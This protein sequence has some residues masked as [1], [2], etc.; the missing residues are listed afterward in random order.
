M[1]IHKHKSMYIKYFVAIFCIA[2]IQTITFAQNSTKSSFRDNYYTAEALLDLG[3]YQEA[4][5]IYLEMSKDAPD[6]DNINFK[7]GFCYVNI[8]LDKHK[9]IPYLEKA[10]QNTSLTYDSNS[11]KETKAPV[12][13]LYWLGKAYHVNYKFEEAINTLNQFRPMIEADNIDLLKSVDITLLNCKNG[14]ELIEKPVKFNIINLGN[15]INTSYSEHSPVF[16]ADESVLIFTS[17]RSGSVGGKK[18]EDGQFYEDIY[19]SLKTDKGWSVPSAISTINS[20][21]NEA[22]IGLSVDGQQLFIY[23]DENGDGNIYFSELNGDTWSVPVKLPEPINTKSRETHASL[24][25]DGRFLYFT[26]DRKGGYGGLD[27]YVS[28]RLPN[29]KWGDVQNLGP[30]INT[31]L[32]EEGPFIHPD[33]VTLFFS[34]EGHQSMGGYDIFYTVIDNETRTCEEPA[35]IGYPINTTEHDVFY[36]PTPDGKRAYYASYQAGGIGNSDIYLITFQDSKEKPL[37]VMSGSISQTTGKV[38]KNVTIT[39]TDLNTKEIVGLYTP[40]S[41][42]GKFLFILTPGNYNILYESDENL[43]FSEN[44]TVDENSSYNQINKA[45]NLAPLVIG[46]T[47]EKYFAEFAPGT[48]EIDDLIAKELDRLTVVLMANKYLIVELISQKNQSKTKLNSDR[49]KSA[50]DY[51]VSKGVD[52]YRIM[53]DLA[54]TPEQDNILQLHITERQDVV[55]Q[56]QNKDVSTNNKTETTGQKNTTEI[57]PSKSDLSITNVFFDFNKHQS[58]S[59][60]EILDK[61][62]SYLLANTDAQIEIQ[63]YTDAQGDASY[64]VMLSVRRANFVKEYLMQKGVSKDLLKIK[65]FGEEMQIASDCCPQSRKYNRRVEFKILKQGSTSKLSVEGIDVPKEYRI[66]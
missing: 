43:F 49:K 66:N 11:E 16:S 1:N 10:S 3:N 12:D 28:K 58:D 35:N 40:N 21:E 20:E 7:I 47:H 13:A 26:S 41:K 32:N 62:A 57:T 53:S 45:I 38:P 18:L 37:T 22:T 23:R 33:G 25:A 55:A 9:A 61:L 31:S 36:M 6:N 30:K 19:Q 46:D 54:K 24:S 15:T 59:Y 27:I 14:I 60:K 48:K 50:T 29:G 8:I 17:K 4:L 44:I 52:L 42:T 64:N 34:S 2:I 39:V 65:G 56:N 5:N 51:L 63:G